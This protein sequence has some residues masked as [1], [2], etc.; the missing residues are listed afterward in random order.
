MSQ[1]TLLSK[2]FVRTLPDDQPPYQV[3]DG[4]YRAL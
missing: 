1:E 3:D 2:F 4:V